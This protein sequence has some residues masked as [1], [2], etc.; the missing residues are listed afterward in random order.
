MALAK[1][2]IMPLAPSALVNQYPNGIDVQFNP[3]SLTI[4]K[5]VT[6]SQRDSTAAGTGAAAAAPGAAGAAAPT[7]A[8]AGTNR[9]LNAPPLTFGGGGARTLTLNLFY[10]VTEQGPTADVRTETNKIV[11]LTLIERTPTPQKPPVVKI[12]WGA[13]SPPGSD[14][15]FTGVVTSLTQ[16]FT[17]FR[18]TG[19]PL[20]ANLTVALTEFI[21][22]E[23][24]KKKTD[25][26]YTTYRVKV[27]DTLSSIAAV[28]YRDPAQWRAIAD[29]NRIDDPRRL[30]VGVRLAIPKRR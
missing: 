22:P 26:D 2:N 30:A 18:S 4:M 7:P 17:L 21:D 20:R 10:D 8:A 23:E 16:N 6:W 15:P 5:P 27:G 19:E 9:D 29:A 13:T 25:P 14:F 24:D 11:K 3:S 28:L 1:L 12:S